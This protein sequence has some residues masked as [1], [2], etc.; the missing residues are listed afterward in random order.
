[1]F[2]HC[3]FRLRLQLQLRL[4]VLTALFGPI[5]LMI[6]GSPDLLVSAGPLRGAGCVRR[7]GICES[8]P[9]AVRYFLGIYSGSLLFETIYRV[10][11]LKVGNDTHTGQISHL[12]VRVL[13]SLL[14]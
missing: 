14:L 10:V 1:M 5:R 11:G 3:S 12:R 8:L 2:V 9:E 4:V 7:V 13:A 6:T